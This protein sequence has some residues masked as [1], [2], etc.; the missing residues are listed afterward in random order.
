MPDKP[1]P[2]APKPKPA[3]KR[4]RGPS[5]LAVITTSLGLFFVVLTLLAIQVR[6]GHDP[7]LGPG[8]VT[9]PAISQPAGA[10]GTSAAVPAQEAGAIVSRTSPAPPP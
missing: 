10:K 7:S 8:L 1:A 2:T 4:R 9:P 3:P 6:S 5:P